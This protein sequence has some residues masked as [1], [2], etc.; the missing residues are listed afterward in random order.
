MLLLM[1]FGATASPACYDRMCIV[2]LDGGASTAA[3]TSGLVRQLKRAL[4]AII[5]PL[6]LTKR[7]F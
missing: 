5:Y 3:K 4:L 6:I 1:A 2:V 7:C